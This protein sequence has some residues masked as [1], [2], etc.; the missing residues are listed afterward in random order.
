MT[1][2][3]DT[4]SLCLLGRGM[5]WQPMLPKLF[6]IVRSPKTSRL[7]PPYKTLRTI[8][9]RNWRC[10]APQ[11]VSIPAN[12]INEEGH[13]APLRR[14]DQHSSKMDRVSSED[15]ARAEMKVSFV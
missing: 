11:S 15:A 6:V 10:S 5:H 3:S 13:R 8:Q 7:H 4:H 12:G 2:A 14:L 9:S 1:K